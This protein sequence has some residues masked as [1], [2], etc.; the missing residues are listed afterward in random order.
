MIDKILDNKINKIIQDEEAIAI[1]LVGSASK[2]ERPNFVVLRD[3]DIF[4]ITEKETFFREVIDIEGIEFDI[5]YLP[6]LLL[7]KAIDEEI[8]SLINVL[9]NSKLLYSSSSSIYYYLDEI[10]KL[11]SKGPKQLEENE[12]KYVRFRLCQTYET[13]L[14]KKSNELNAVFLLNNFIKELIYSYFKLNRIW[15]PSEKKVIYTIEITDN[16]LYSLIVN[17]YKNYD[18]DRKIKIARDILDYVTKP[19][20]GEL[21]QWE[22]A[23]Y[24]FDFN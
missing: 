2:T 4:V 11:Y 5:S 23:E 18:T 12:I 15:T 17:F 3:I 8:P 22:K 1:L 16:I 14:N 19:F 13:I 24:P 7:K 20:G 21:N 6:K 9:Y 10:K